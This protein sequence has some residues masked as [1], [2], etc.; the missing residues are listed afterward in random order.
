MSSI[1]SSKLH[2]CDFN[3][4]FKATSKKHQE[5]SKC[6]SI[7]YQPYHTFTNQT[8][9]CHTT[10][11]FCHII[12]TN[13]HP[14]IKPLHSI[15]NHTILL[16]YHYQ[17]KKYNYQPYHTIPSFCHIISITDHTIIKPFY[18]ITRPNNCS[19]FVDFS[20]CVFFFKC[21]KM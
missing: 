15:T 3:L 16:L 4:N 21:K 11:S 6:S 9:P 12:T 5:D 19:F 1:I 13:N 10:P 17:D 8:M 14:I 7:H 20:L 2:R 18:S